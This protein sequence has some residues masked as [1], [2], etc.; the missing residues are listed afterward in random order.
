MVSEVNSHFPREKKGEGRD[1]HPE[2]EE[3]LVQWKLE[4]FFPQEDSLELKFNSA[5]AMEA[6]TKANRSD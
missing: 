3:H 6:S 4:T 2:G 5:E 1:S